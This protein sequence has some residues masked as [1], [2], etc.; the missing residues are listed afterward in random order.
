MYTLTADAGSFVLTGNSSGL[1]HGIR[2]T[3]SA[4]T[5]TL[6]G[7]DAVLHYLGFTLTAGVGTFLARSFG[8]GGFVANSNATDLIGPVVGQWDR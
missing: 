2:F 5:F 3:V 8:S 7:Y 4:G 1:V 6:V